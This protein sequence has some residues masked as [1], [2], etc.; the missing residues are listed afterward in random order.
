MEESLKKLER[1]EMGYFAYHEMMPE[2]VKVVD[3]D[4]IRPHYAYWTVAYTITPAAAKKLIETDIRHNIIPVDE[5]LPRMQMDVVALKEPCCRQETR[6]QLGTDVEPS[7]ESDYVVDFTTHALTCGSDPERMS[8]LTESAARND[9]K[10]TNIFDLESDVWG[11]GTMVGPGGGQ[12]INLIR[13]YIQD[14]PDH[15]VV[16][17]TDAYDVVY[18][19]DLE[20]ITG[21][22]LGFKH[23][24]LFSAEQLL[25]PNPSL[26]FPPAPTK[27]RFLNS[28]T[29]IGRVGEVKR[30][31]EKPIADGQDDQL[32][33]QEAF[34]TGQHDAVL[35]YE[36][37]IFQC[38]ETNTEIKNGNIYNP[39]TLCFPSYL[40][41]KW[42]K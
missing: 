36:G 40:P 35:D 32:Y 23:E 19:R 17:F 27:Y 10:V 1:Y 16:L 42:R 29:F 4:L 7:S 39:E 2:S 21:R 22:F 20:T 28:G 37:Y 8:M 13:R 11:G 12:K 15:D 14:L 41:C 24:V 31:L 33:L 18:L 38:H 26:L 30:M 34:L 6:S 3:H 5:Y 9:V 25:W